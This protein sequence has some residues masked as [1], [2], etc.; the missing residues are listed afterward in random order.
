M[1]YR[2]VLTPFARADIIELLAWSV[3]QFSDD[4]RDGYEELLDTVLRD[5]STNPNLVGSHERNELGQDVRMV[6]LRTCRDRV[7]GDVRRIA[8][9]VHVV[10]YRAVRDTVYVSRVLH[11]ARNFADHPFP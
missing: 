4:V 3:D 1:T 6:H 9:P 7:A 2:V 10:F 5:I 11:E 8:S